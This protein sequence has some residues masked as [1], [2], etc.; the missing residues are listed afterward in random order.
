MAS[1]SQLQPR[2]SH[3]RGGAQHFPGAAERLHREIGADGPGRHPDRGLEPAARHLRHGR[4]ARGARPC[5]Q[6]PRADERGA[7]PA[8]VHAS[9]R[10]RRR[11]GSRTPAGAR[12]CRSSRSGSRDR[13]RR[14]SGKCASNSSWPCGL[15][16]EKYGSWP[17]PTNQSPL[18]SACTL[19]WLSASSGGVWVRR[20]TS[21]A[22][23]GRVAEADDDAA[24]LA[25]HLRR[26]AVVE[27]ADRAVGQFARIVLPGVPVPAPILK[28]VCLPPRRQTIWPVR[29]SRSYTVQVL[30]L[31]IS[32]LPSRSRLIELRWKKSNGVAVFERLAGS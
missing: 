19:P 2:L 26:G 24:R 32:R 4:E 28:L 7:V 29:A 11:P 16:S 1:R 22:V 14:A 21:V 20:V 10:S 8:G 27:D 12:A 30:R 13:T 6:P 31:E 23:P 17:Q 3:R 18:A 15:N 9:C 25:V 5:E